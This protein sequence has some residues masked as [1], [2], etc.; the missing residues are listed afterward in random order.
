MRT[1]CFACFV[2]LRALLQNGFL[3]HAFYLTL[4]HVVKYLK[5][6]TIEAEGKNGFCLVCVDSYPL[7]WGKLN[8]GTL[9]N[10]YLS[11]WRLM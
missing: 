7:G 5:G 1:H 8:N 9:K 4:C 3:V 2:K 10:K 11:G 6:E